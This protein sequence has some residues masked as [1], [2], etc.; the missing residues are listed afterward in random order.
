MQPKL[1]TITLDNFSAKITR[2]TDGDINSGFAKYATTSGVDVISNPKV[3][4]F[5]QTATSIGGS[6]VTDLIVAGRVRLENS[7]TYLYAI[8]HLGRLYKI[9]VNDP[10]GKNPAYNNPVLL[11]TLAN[12]QTF[13]YGGSLDFFQVSGTTYIWIGHDTGVTRIN[14]DGTSETVISGTWVANVPRQE[15][16]F[17]G[18]LYYTNGT[19]LAVIDSTGTVTSSA[20]LNPGF[21]ATMQARDIDTTANGAYIVITVSSIPL[22]SILNTVPDPNTASGG[23]SL[24]VYWNGTDTAASLSN[25]FPSFAQTAYQTFANSEYSF[26][27]DSYGA[28]VSNPIDKILTLTNTQ[29]PLPNAIFSSGN[30]LNWIVP[31][32]YNGALVASIY[33]FGQFDQDYE[34]SFYR[35]VRISSSLSGGDMIKVPFASLMTNQTVGGA[36]SGYTGNI[37][38]LSTM[39]FSTLEYNGTT[40]AYKLYAFNLLPTST[41]TAVG[42]VYETLNQIFSQ[43]VRIPQIRVYQNPAIANQSYTIDLIGIDGN[44][45]T[46]GSKTFTT[47][48]TMTVGDVMTN[49]SPSHSPT[50]VFGVRITNVGSVTPV[51]QKIELD[52]AQAGI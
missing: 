7:A 24:L 38:G 16:Q 32:A 11:A 17:T 30:M 10:N 36:T 25:S 41:G 3:L 28:Q 27:Y 48:S 29:S 40:T 14:L 49:Y 43:K 39:Y 26:G 4:Q 1:Q 19:N 21:P 33:S 42:G 51:I 45:I 18:K 13:N 20:I 15:I 2:F 34:P 37:I 46:G 5:M 47:G 6:V 52:Y 44:I 23:S 50:P 31:E 22:V 8:G 12:G 35:R 9:Q